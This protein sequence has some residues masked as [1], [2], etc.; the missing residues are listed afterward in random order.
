M[1]FEFKKPELS[2][3]QDVLKTSVLILLKEIITKRRDYICL[4]GLMCA[5]NEMLSE[6]LL[7]KLV[8]VP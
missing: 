5:I 1:D 3:R 6:K 2:S 8:N 7:F 4:A